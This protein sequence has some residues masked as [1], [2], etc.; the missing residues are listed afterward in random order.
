MPGTAR[1]LHNIVRDS[2][3]SVIGGWGGGKLVI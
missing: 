2:A 3:E 1:N